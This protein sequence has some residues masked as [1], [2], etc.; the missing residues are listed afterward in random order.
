MITGV[1]N[2]CFDRETFG[3]AAGRAGWHWSATS[4]SMTMSLKCAPVHPCLLYTSDAAADLLRVDLGGR[5][6][7]KKKKKKN[8]HRPTTSHNAQHTQPP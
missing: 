5:R 8:T 3:A 6:N 7:I 1:K 2:G 4:M